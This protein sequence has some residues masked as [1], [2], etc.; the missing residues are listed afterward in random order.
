[1]KLSKRVFT[2]LCASLLPFVCCVMVSQSFAETCEC[3]SPCSGSRTCPDGCWAFCEDRESGPYCAKGCSYD[4]SAMTIT[5]K[6]SEKGKLHNV[7]IKLPTELVKPLL[8]RIFDV[9]LISIPTAS[10]QE[11]VDVKLKDTN[12]GELLKALKDQGV[13]LQINNK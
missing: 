4:I 10:K 9:T 13:A 11:N 8:E 12:L 1:M 2:I 3:D 5:D 6:L 7:D